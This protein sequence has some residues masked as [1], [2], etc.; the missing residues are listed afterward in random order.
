MQDGSFILGESRAI[1]AYLVNSRAPGHSLYPVDPKVRAL[2]DSRL[3]YDATIVFPK[4]IEI[5]V[6]LRINNF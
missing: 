4:I 1:A 5:I 2:I 3:Y 6:S